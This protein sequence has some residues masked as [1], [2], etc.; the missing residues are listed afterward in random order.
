MVDR[1]TD[2]LLGCWTCPYTSNIDNVSIA[3]AWCGAR[4]PYDN[5]RTLVREG[6]VEDY[7]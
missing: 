5:L 4:G 2:V 6:G 1:M 7:A 3:L